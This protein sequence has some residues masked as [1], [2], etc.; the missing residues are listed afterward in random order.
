MQIYKVKE[1]IYLVHSTIPSNI[2]EHFFVAENDLEFKK[3]FNSFQKHREERHDDIQLKFVYEWRRL[4]N[5][6]IRFC[7][8]TFVRTKDVSKEFKELLKEKYKEIF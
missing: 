3:F 5:F 1:Y 4:T 6:N 8:D 7:R 2:Y